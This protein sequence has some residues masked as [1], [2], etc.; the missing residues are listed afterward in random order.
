VRNLLEQLVGEMV[1]RGIDFEDG[2][3]EFDKAFI[4]RMLEKCDGNL[5]KAADKLGMHRN[6]LAR[7]LQALKI[8]VPRG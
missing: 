5:G 4:A 8:K 3:R 6:T 1:D 2:Q 7:K